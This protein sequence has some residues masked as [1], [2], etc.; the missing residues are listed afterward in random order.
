ME[1]AEKY[2]IRT[3][4]VPQSPATSLAAHRNLALVCDS[5]S[6]GCVTRGE[7]SAAKTGAQDRWK[8]RRGLDPAWGALWDN[9]REARQERTTR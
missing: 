9:R 6:E 1:F 4:N 2:S 3:Y 7:T 8:D 5:E